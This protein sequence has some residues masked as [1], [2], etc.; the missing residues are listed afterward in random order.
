MFLGG[1]LLGRLLRWE[2][3]SLF[4]KKREKVRDYPVRNKEV[5]VVSSGGA[6]SIG[7]GGI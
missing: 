2:F 6:Q 7:P 3:V 4:A 1:A 5:I